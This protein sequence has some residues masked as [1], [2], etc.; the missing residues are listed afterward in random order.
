MIGGKATAVNLAYRF[1]AQ[2]FDKLLAVDDL[3]GSCTAVQTPINLPLWD[4]LA[5]VCVLLHLRGGRRHLAT[6]SR[7]G[8]T[9]GS[10]G[11]KK[12]VRRSMARL[13]PGGAARRFYRTCPPLYML[14]PS[15]SFTSLHTSDDKPRV[16]FFDDCGIGVPR[17][18]TKIALRTTTKF[19]GALFADRVRGRIDVKSPWAYRQLPR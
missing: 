2:Q 10:R 11:L 4:H 17:I 14:F 5:R 18:L 16:G 19:N 9:C 6:A 1:G 13:R 15:E 3:K 7:K 12:S 8:R